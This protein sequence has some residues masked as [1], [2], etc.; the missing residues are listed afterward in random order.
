[1]KRRRNGNEQSVG[2]GLQMMTPDQVTEFFA[3]AERYNKLGS[4]L[5][6]IETEN[7]LNDALATEIQIV[8]DQMKTIKAAMDALMETRH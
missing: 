8:L 1:M 2:G 4:R 7:D 6:K 3:L 5:P